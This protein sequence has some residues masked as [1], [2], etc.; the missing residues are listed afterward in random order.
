MLGFS[1]RADETAKKQFSER[2]KAMLTT[3]LTAAAFKK[4]ASSDID[5]A[6]KKWGSEFFQNK[7]R[8]SVMSMFEEAEKIEWHD[9]FSGAVVWGGAAQGATGISACY[10]PWSDAIVLLKIEGS[11]KSQKITDFAVV[12]GESWREETPKTADE[13]FH[14]N[15]GTQPL[16]IQL[17]SYYDRTLDVFNTYYSQPGKVALL[18]A[19]FEK[20]FAPPDEELAVIKTRMIQR[21]FMYQQLFSK[22][23]SSAKELAGKIITAIN[24]KGDDLVNIMEPGNSAEAAADYGKLP[25]TFR[26]EVGPIYFATRGEGFILAFV[27]ANAPKY[28]LII[29]SP[30]TPGKKGKLTCE[31]INLDLSKQALTLWKEVAK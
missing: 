31:L 14:L 2:D 7:W 21:L 23:H 11:L 4:D 12:C 22:K 26:Q 8:H 17:A 9:F 13:L 19:G 18:P 30:D 1:A 6:V 16:L 28:I 27:S 25:E 24:A 29:A 5:A 20:R 10:N 3:A 15:N